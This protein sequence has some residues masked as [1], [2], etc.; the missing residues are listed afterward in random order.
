M[1]W[2]NPPKIKIYE[3]L[4]ALADGRIREEDGESRC[5]SSS[6]NKYYIVE[7]DES[8]AAIMAN[9][10]GSYWRGYLG[11]PAIAHLMQIGKLDYNKKIAEALKSF[12]WKDINT[13]N[14]NDFDKTLEIAQDKI[15]KIGVGADELNLYIDGVSKQIFK[16]D[17]EYFGKKKKPPKGY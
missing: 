9:D 7:Y 11:Y 3:A 8:R 17:L 5:Y 13:K 4:G 15:I 16:L 12:A 10:N 6:G 14:K 2:K 1:K